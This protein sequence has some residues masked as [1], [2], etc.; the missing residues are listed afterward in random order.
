MGSRRR[1][2]ELALQMLY[3]HEVTE[4]APSVIREDF[5]DWQRAPEGVQRF[6][7]ELV[8]GVLEHLEEIDGR[9]SHQTANWRLDR[10]A[11]VDRNILRIAM[12]ELLFRQETPPAV[13]I[14]EAIE[15]AKR[16]GAE[17]SGRFVNGVLDGFVKGHE[18]E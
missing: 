17:D 15:V 7:N 3:Q 12:F 16:F 4:E 2:R 18:R 11:A 13:V 8:D 5:D 10:L 14:D 6:A 9:L 1:A